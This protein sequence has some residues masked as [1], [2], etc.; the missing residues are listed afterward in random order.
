MNLPDVSAAL[1]GWTQPLTI[2]T[3]TTTTVNFEPTTVVNCEPFEAVVQPTQKTRLNADQLDWSR[4]H[5][6]FH[7]EQPMD[8]GQLVEYKG[9]DYKIV[10]LADYSDYGYFEGVG[11]AT[12]EEALECTL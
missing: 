11:E 10:E 12:N 6:T 4:V 7:S 5:Q 8:Y 3:V 9:K 2:K 1:L